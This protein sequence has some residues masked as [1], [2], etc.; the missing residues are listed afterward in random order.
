M[1]GPRAATDADHIREYSLSSAF[2]KASYMAK[3]FKFSSEAED[4]C[5]NSCSR[6][7]D[8]D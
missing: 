4:I 6:S 8:A 1:E 5:Y 2:S 7:D 3:E